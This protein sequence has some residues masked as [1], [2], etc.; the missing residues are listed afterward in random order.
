MRP[1][2]WLVLTLLFSAMPIVCS[3]AD[4][5]AKGAQVSA[6]ASF[7]CKWW[8]VDQMNGLD[9]NKPPPKN[10]EIAIEKWDYSDP[11]GT[12]H[13]DV[14]D[15]AVEIR[16]ESDAPVTA[17][18]IEIE[19]QWKVGPFSKETLAKWSTPVKLKSIEPSSVA[20]HQAEN[21]RVPINVAAKM[22]ELKSSKGWPYAF[23]GKATVIKDGSTVATAE[24]E[25]AILKGD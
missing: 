9:P 19:G 23:R 18:S 12:P 1:P 24:S 7:L 3:Q 8:S 20:S 5:P 11:V 4:T 22:A 10:T 13:P 16:N 15:F 2:K 14:V 25:L 21:V 17:V 6:R